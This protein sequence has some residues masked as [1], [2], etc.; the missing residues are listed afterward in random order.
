MMYPDTTD[1]VSDE[2]EDPDVTSSSADYKLKELELPARVAEVREGYKLNDGEGFII[3][4]EGDTLLYDFQEL[5]PDGNL[6][7]ALKSLTQVEIL[8]GR[9]YLVAMRVKNESIDGTSQSYLTDEN[10]IAPPTRIQ[11]NY[12][13]FQSQ[14]QATELK[15]YAV[16]TIYTWH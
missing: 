6:T 1:F 12:N 3:P 5:L 16:E 8:S 11:P 10:K 14:S 9:T 7:K 2:P 4:N 13:C 15:G